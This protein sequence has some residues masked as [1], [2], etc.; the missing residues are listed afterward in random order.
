MARILHTKP[1]SK[2]YLSE[3]T[4]RTLRSPCMPITRK[5]LSTKV[6]KALKKMPPT[7]LLNQFLTLPQH[8]GTSARIRMMIMYV[9]WSMMMKRR[10]P[11]FTRKFLLS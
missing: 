5:V 1:A 10:P 3:Y 7:L 11:R 9:T 4:S 8:H 6:I 2:W